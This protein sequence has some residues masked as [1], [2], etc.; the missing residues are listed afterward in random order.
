MWK[1]LQKCD[2][3]LFPNSI[4]CGLEWFHHFL[5]HSYFV[6]LLNFLE[7]RKAI[8]RIL[9][10]QSFQRDIHHQVMREVLLIKYYVNIVFREMQVIMRQIKSCQGMNRPVCYRLKD[11]LKI[12]KYRGW[13]MEAIYLISQTHISLKSCK[14]SF[15]RELR[16][17]CSSLCQWVLNFVERGTASL[18][19]DVWYQSTQPA[20]TCSKLTIETLEK[21]VKYVQS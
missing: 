7:E 9:S 4:Y 6:F 8:I 3:W 20:I 12:L 14:T 16:K 5:P 19:M 1:Y 2:T 18:F 17:R 15:A 13:Q 11:R 10:Y 21:G